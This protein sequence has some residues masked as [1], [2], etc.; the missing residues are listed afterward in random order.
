[1]LHKS[2]VLIKKI[3]K[4]SSIVLLVFI[5]SSCVSTSDV[6]D[7][8]MA[9]RIP[10]ESSVFIIH[11]EKENQDLFD[12]ITKKLVR[13][14]YRIEADKD[15]L[16]IETEGVDIGEST[17]ARYTLYIEDGSVTGRAN[18][19]IGSQAHAM[20]TVLS[21]VNMNANWE[22]AEWTTGRPKRAYASLIDF[23]MQFEHIN[24][25]FN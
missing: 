13:D 16:T 21:G 8:T 10:E 20:A 25:E 2:Q 4:L 6:I 11:T 18:W 9:N 14:G 23:M 3:I 5:L 15:L 19:M 17:F 1:M 24:Y 22:K 7:D 12:E